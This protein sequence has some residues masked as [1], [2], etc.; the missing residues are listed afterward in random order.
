[1]NIFTAEYTSDYTYF[2]CYNYIAK[3]PT[4]KTDMQISCS[5]TL[6]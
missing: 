6:D 1:M 5:L 2:K 3:L 4:K